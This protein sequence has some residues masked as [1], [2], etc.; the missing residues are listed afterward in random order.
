[1]GVTE[2]T[3]AGLRVTHCKSCGAEIVFAPRWDN[4]EGKVMPIDAA[5]VADG[6][7][8]LHGGTY[9]VVNER[10]PD[11]VREAGLHRTHWQTCPRPQ[12]FRR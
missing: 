7:I 1:M 2:A 10:T 8:A 4:P 5:V 12:P 11:V 6:A 9:L 3:I